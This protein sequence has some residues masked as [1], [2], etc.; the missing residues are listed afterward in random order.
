VIRVLLVLLVGAAAVWLV[1]YGVHRWERGAAERRM[2]APALVEAPAA[3]PAVQQLPNAAF[4]PRP[5]SGARRSSFLARPSAA[6][7]PAD[8]R[9]VYQAGD[10]LN[11]TLTVMALGASGHYS[12]KII[13]SGLETVLVEQ[14]IPAADLRAFEERFGRWLERRPLEGWREAA[15]VPHTLDPMQECRLELTAGGHSV[16]RVW[17]AYDAARQRQPV[18]MI[19]EFLGHVYLQGVATAF[20]GVALENGA[21]IR[22]LEDSSFLAWTPREPAARRRL[23]DAGEALNTAQFFD[24]A[25]QG[26][27]QEV[28][29]FC[30][31]GLDV[32]ARNWE[33]ETAL[34]AAARGDQ[35]AVVRALLAEGADPNARYP[36]TCHASYGGR[37]VAGHTPLMFAAESGNAEMAQA[38]L[39]A[40]ARRE[41]GDRSGRTA[42]WIAEEKGFFNVANLLMR[43]SL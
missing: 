6:A 15:E 28:R 34:L 11:R 25:F 4:L 19:V 29:W 43:S 20:R 18:A 32:N 40:G 16:V 37:G 36:E 41:T 7:L 39:D 24:E 1:V 26:H 27:M 5:S 12:A 42:R 2:A 3:K 31:S 14:A 21:V 22:M 17:S 35:T 13:Q 30:Q 38:L 33:G 8:F 23:I 10:A 9:I